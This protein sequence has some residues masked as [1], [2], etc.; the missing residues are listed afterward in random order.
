MVYIPN[1]D[2][3]PGYTIMQP[4][5]VD[6]AEYEALP[7]GEHVCPERNASILSR[8]YFGWMTPLLQLGY[9][10]PITEKDVWKLDT[11]DQTKILI[12]KFQR[13]WIEESQRSKPWLLRALNNSF[14]GRFWLGGLFKHP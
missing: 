2:P 14:G 10:K 7:G 11:W 6:N 3:Y 13:C 4:E 8:T 9:K 5:F 1:L 12:E